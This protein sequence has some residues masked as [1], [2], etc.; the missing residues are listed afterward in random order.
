MS[1][2][3][4]LLDLASHVSQVPSDHW[5]ICI[6]KTRVHVEHS[7]TARFSFNVSLCKL[8]HCDVFWLSRIIS[9]YI[10]VIHETAQNFI[11]LESPIHGASYT[12]P[13][14][15]YLHTSVPNHSFRQKSN[16]T[17]S[18]QQH[19]L[20][21]IKTST[22]IHLIKKDI[23]IQRFTSHVK[24][25]VKQFDSEVEEVNKKPARERFWFVSQRHVKAWLLMIRRAAFFL[26]RIFS[27]NFD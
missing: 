13:Q 25:L 6:I 8:I 27:W 19:F 22:L 3:I 9:F 10:A 23:K 21:A 1:V 2:A 16:E 17:S 20:P 24:A 12:S 14:M 5:L 18:R 15:A 7:L 26:L 11:E 4:S